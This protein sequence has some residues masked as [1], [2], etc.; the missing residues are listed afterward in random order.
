[1]AEVMVD[2]LSIATFAVSSLSL[3][4]N[5]LL[6]VLYYRCPV[7]KMGS[8]KYFLLL[9][10]LQNIVFSIVLIMSVPVSRVLSEFFTP[11]EETLFLEWYEYLLLR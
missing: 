11:Y 8:F 1:M 10:A 4:L 7:S 5:V 2:F 9:T 3:L 6:L